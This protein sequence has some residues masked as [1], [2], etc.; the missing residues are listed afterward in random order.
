[1]E[2]L[3]DTLGITSLPKSQ[4]SVMAKELKGQVGAFRNRPLGQGPYTFVIADALVLKARENG[5][6][7]IVHALV[8]V[9]VNADGYRE[10]LGM[11]SPPPKTA[12]AD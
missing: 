3:V 11:M 2:K 12:P 6:V 8:A 5:R 10:T 1:M 4:V 7:V 9:G